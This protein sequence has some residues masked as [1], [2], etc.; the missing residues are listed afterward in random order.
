MLAER[1]DFIVATYSSLR[2]TGE[3]STVSIFT[4]NAFGAGGF[5][6]VLAHPVVNRI[7]AK[8]K[9]LATIK[10]SFVNLFMRPFVGNASSTK[11]AVWICRDSKTA[12]GRYSFADGWPFR[13]LRESG[14]RCV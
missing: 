4:G 3:R 9:Q 8:T 6:S 13:V 5:A 12:T 2:G 14:L 1:R 7:P 10:V 11:D